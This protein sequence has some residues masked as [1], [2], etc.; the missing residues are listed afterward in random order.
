[1]LVVVDLLGRESERA[2]KE[3]VGRQNHWELIL[4]RSRARR[5]GRTIAKL[6]AP[7][8]LSPSDDP[9]PYWNPN[10][11]RLTGRSPRRAAWKK[12]PLRE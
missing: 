9:P 4:T 10:L 2:A 6:Y 7:L 11:P 8:L 12:V 1:M 5:V 3:V